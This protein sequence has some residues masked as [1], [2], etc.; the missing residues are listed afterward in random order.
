MKY[1]LSKASLFVALDV[2]NNYVQITG[3]SYNTPIQPL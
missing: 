3:I 1:I 2:G